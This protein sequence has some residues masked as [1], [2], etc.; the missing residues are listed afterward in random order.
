MILEIIEGILLV[1]E[2]GIMLGRVVGL[3]CTL[4][5]VGLRA[6]SPSFTI[7]GYL[8]SLLYHPIFAW[9]NKVKSME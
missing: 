7:L 9:T 3:L 5:L 2:R 1:G 4:G 8:R 6:M